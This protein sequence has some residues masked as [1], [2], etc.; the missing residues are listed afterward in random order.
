LMSLRI[1]TLLERGVLAIGGAVSLLVLA[2]VAALFG[3]LPLRDLVRYGYLEAN[4]YGQLFHATV[5][6]VGIPYAVVAD[7]HVR[8]DLMRGRFSPRVRALIEALGHL[9]FVIP[10]TLVLSI[11]AADPVWRS[12]TLGERFPNTGNA[13]YA[14]MRVAF[15][16]FLVLLA[17]ASASRVIRS[18]NEARG[19]GPRSA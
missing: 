11:Y 13:G 4:D 14:L 2:V 12:I 9:L 16:L 17:A 1:A 19:D 18:L 10:W 6:L 8:L 3:Q 7:R 5:F 15:V